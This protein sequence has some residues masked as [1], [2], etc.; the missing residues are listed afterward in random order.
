MKAVSEQAD[1]LRSISFHGGEPF[2]YIKR[3]DELLELIVPLFPDMEYY[4]TSNGSHVV[5]NEWFFEKWAGKIHVTLSYDFNFQEVNR[6]YVDVVAL[7][8]VLYRHNCYLMYQFVVPPD[9][10]REDT[11]ASVISTMRKT[12]CNT[13]NLIPLRHYRGKEKFKVLIDDIDLKWYMVDM[14]RFIQ[15]LYAYGIT[16]NIDGNY[17]KIDKHYLDNHGKV[18]LSPDGYLYPE[19]DYVEYKRHEFRVGKWKNGIEIYRKK[20]ES[21]YLLPGCLSCDLYFACGLKYLYKMFDETPKGN[22]VEFYKVIDLMVKHLSKLKQE[23]TF[24]HWIGI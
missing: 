22:C 21:E 20:D 19:F 1:D 4:I 10:F 18:I 23:K 14:M 15:A 8:E 17:D 12:H 6:E 13:I 3:I 7:S 24:M 9:G 5:D 16:I 2:L 11:L